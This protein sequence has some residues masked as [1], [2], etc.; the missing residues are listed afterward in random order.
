MMRET[1]LDLQIIGFSAAIAGLDDRRAGE[2]SLPSA[3][4][5]P[6][7]QESFALFRFCSPLGGIPLSRL[8]PLSQVPSR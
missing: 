6:L 1:P 7:L 4:L 8:L 5:D 2:I 3:T